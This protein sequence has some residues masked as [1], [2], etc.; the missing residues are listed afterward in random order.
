MCT[1]TYIP[2]HDGFVLSS[3]RDEVL[4]RLAEKPKWRRNSGVSLF[5]PKDPKAEGTWIAVD[6]NYQV[7]CLLNGA[8]QKH[9]S[10]A[11]YLKSRGQMVLEC[12][13]FED[14]EE[15]L[16]TYDFTELEPFT[17]I[18]VR[19]SG[20]FE[21]RWDCK[22]LHVKNCDPTKAQIWSSVT[23]YDPGAQVKRREAFD[24]WLGRH[25]EFEDARIAGFHLS[26]HGLDIENDILMKRK[27][28]PNTT[29]FS[30]FRKYG[31]LRVFS[32]LDIPSMT[33]QSQLL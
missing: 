33:G 20:F 12:F 27:N 26:T 10:G 9:C 2:T 31:N 13:H 15:F 1:V 4:D 17:L 22:Q 16:K 5:Y 7:A 23:L 28:G 21:I 30:Q 6:N 14:T 25:S 29:S 11:T 24:A 32:Y 18:L 3:N 19:R 8:F